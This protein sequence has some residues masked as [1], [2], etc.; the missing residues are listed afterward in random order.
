MPTKSNDTSVMLAET[1]VKDALARVGINRP[2][3]LGLDGDFAWVDSFMRDEA[4]RE[5]IK[6]L[7]GEIQ[8]IQALPLDLDGIK[9]RAADLI[10]KY[11]QKRINRLRNIFAA[12][13]KGPGPAGDV[14]G[15]SQPVL[16]LSNVTPEELEEVFSSDMFSGGISEKDRQK[17]IDKRQERIGQVQDRM[18]NDKESSP[19]S[20]WLY[21]HDGSAIRY[22]LGCKWTIIVNAWRTLAAK[23]NEPVNFEG[24]AIEGDE[25]EFAVWYKLGLDKIRKEAGGTSI[26][27][28]SKK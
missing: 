9:K 20:R 19:S 2:I 3:R 13:Q 22:P 6:R 15:G 23:C 16:I 18:D 4:D 7:Q 10:E 1:L 27:P 11:R 21:N 17:K 25:R 14:I 26:T 24:Y 8:E 5:E 28:R 12:E